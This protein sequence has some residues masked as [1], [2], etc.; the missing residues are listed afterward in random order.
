METTHHLSQI[1]AKKRSIKVGVDRTDKREA[2]DYQTSIS[3]EF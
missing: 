3:S 2:V 1:T